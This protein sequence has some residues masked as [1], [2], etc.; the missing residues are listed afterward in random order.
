MTWLLLGCALSPESTPLGETP[1][2]D[3][4]ELTPEEIRFRPLMCGD[5]AIR[6]GGIRRGDW[7]LEN[8]Q[9][10]IGIRSPGS[11]LST[12][13]G[14]GGSVVDLARFEGEDSMLE[15]LPYQN[16]VLDIEDW[17]ITETD[18]DITLQFVPHEAGIRLQTQQQELQFWGDVEWLFRPLEGT[19]RI[20]QELR[21]PNQENVLYIDG[22]INDLGGDL[23]LSELIAIH[24]DSPSTIFSS[25]DAV[26]INISA[27]GDSLV[28]YHENE[29]L[30]F[31]PIQAPSAEEEYGLAVGYLLSDTTHIQAVKDGCIP[32]SLIEIQALEEEISIGDCGSV[33]IRL[34]EDTEER[35]GLLRTGEKTLF[36][37]KDGERIPLSAALT[38]ITIDAG[39]EFEPLNIRRL[40]PFIHPLLELHLQRALPETHSMSLHNLISS[41][42]ETRA[43]RQKILLEN[44]GRQLDYV[45]LSAQNVVPLENN[46]LPYYL[47][48]QLF[49]EEGLFSIHPSG[50]FLS[51]PWTSRPQPAFG[52][53]R[54]DTLSL[55][56]SLL[57]GMQKD[58]FLFLNYS[59]LAEIRQEPLWQAP[60]FLRIT[61]AE[62]AL[63][64]A[65]NCGEYPYSR[66]AS[67][68]VWLPHLNTISPSKVEFEHE[69]RTGSLGLGNGPLLKI[70]DASIQERFT[71]LQLYLHGNQEN[72]P[73]Y[74]RIYSEQGQEWSQTLSEFPFIE[75]IVLPKRDVF[76]LVAWSDALGDTPWALS[77]PLYTED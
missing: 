32:S 41:D 70:S 38:D 64:F 45:L 61:S 49:V 63:D 69:L 37:A 31:I 18:H 62:E 44:I 11:S 57:I 36:I 67:D 5:D 35:N 73:Q 13:A 68:H 33:L 59:E 53:I 3:P 25:Q 60:D 66:P 47:Q 6:G 7:I 56:E 65:Q 54:V 12:L 29:T 22:T 40:D 48:D 50:S 55:E 23:L 2:C 71:R 51:F 77:T 8:N 43:S 27:N 26:P 52:A 16:G 1:A 19:E 74:L 14:S 75:T 28:A 76:C 20:G 30:G 34:L 17:E 46:P 58:R 10:R 4:R 24:I 9:L 72:R 15:I 39:F 21:L 42:S